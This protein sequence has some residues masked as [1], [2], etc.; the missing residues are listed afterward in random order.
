MCKLLAISVNEANR[1]GLTLKVHVLEKVNARLKSN[2]TL[3]FFLT[4]SVVKPQ[5]V[6][7]SQLAQ[8]VGRN[9]AVG[10]PSETNTH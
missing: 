5:S 9:D 4:I 10:S 1:D 7:D 8:N 2:I 3:M 6:N